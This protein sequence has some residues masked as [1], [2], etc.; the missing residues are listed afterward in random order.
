MT[1]HANKH[2]QCIHYSL[3]VLGKGAVFAAENHLMRTFCALQSIPEPPSLLFLD[4]AAADHPV[5]EEAPAGG[6]PHAR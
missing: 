5:E 6:P 3:L 2:D 4:N 1:D